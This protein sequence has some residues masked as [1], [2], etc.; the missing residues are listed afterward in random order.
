VDVSDPAIPVEIGS[1]D[2]P[3]TAG[4]VAVSSDPDSG[5]VHTYVADRGT[6]LR[7]LDVSD[8]SIPT[9]VA[10]LGT[11]GDARNVASAEGAYVYIAGGYIGLRIVDISDPGDPTESG[12]YDTPGCRGSMPTLPMGPADC[13]L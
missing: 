8:P 1:Y 13:A 10:F 12:F 3:T 11:I 7:I 9:E 6:G 5:L 2:V 4:A